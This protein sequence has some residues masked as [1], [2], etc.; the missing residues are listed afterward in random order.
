MTNKQESAD[1]KSDSDF[2]Y[3]SQLSIYY[4]VVINDSLIQQPTTITI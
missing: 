2:I 1:V 3:N 4:A